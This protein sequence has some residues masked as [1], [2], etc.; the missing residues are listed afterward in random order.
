L[1]KT[2]CQLL[3][4]YPLAS[5]H[6]VVGTYNPHLLYPYD[7]DLA[8]ALGGSDTKTIEPE[9]MPLSWKCHNYAY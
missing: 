7:N 4:E 2:S 3:A 5:G 1:N 8:A 9:I 6:S